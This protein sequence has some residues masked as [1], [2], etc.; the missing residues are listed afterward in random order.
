MPELTA[1]VLGIF[2]VVHFLVLLLTATL[3]LRL[4]CWTFNKLNGL[5]PPGLGRSDS[6]DYTLVSSA[7][8]RF[9]SPP[10][11]LTRYDRA[12]T[13]AGGVPLPGFFRSVGVGLTFTLAA[14]AVFWLLLLVFSAATSATGST[15]GMSLL[16]S[17]LT[18]IPLCVLMMAGLVSLI[19]PTTFPRA[20]L[21]SLVFSLMV[22]TLL[23]LFGIAGFLITLAAGYPLPTY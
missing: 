4:S 1:A 2:A 17:Q 9:Y 23:A 3:L 15:P 12:K 21:V 13:A 8:M 18:A 22:L 10:S 20:L 5:A 7:D 6:R 19:L 16:L 14:S 11:A